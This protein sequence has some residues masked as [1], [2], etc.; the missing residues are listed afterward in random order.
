MIGEQGR[1]TRGFRTVIKIKGKHVRGG[2]V[3][4]WVSCKLTARVAQL[5]TALRAGFSIVHRRRERCECVTFG[6]LLWF[7]G[8]LLGNLIHR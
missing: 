8:R 5:A 7:Q 1:A 6:F 4:D 3:E 2:E